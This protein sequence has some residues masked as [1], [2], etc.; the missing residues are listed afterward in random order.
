MLEYLA[1]IAHLTAVRGAFGVPRIRMEDDFIKTLLVKPHPQICHPGKAFDH[2]GKC[3][4]RGLRDFIMI[5]ETSDLI[6]AGVLGPDSSP[7]C[8]QRGFRGDKN[9]KGEMISSKR[10]LKPHLQ[11][12]HPGKAFDHQGKC[13]IRGLRDFIMTEETF[14]LIDAGVLDPDSSPPCSQRGFR[15]DKNK[16]G[17]MI[18]SKRFLKPH[19]QICHPGKAFDHQGKCLI[20]GLRDFIM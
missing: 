8:S 10:F 15:G 14:D 1:R 17:E 9:K 12:C 3:L 13:L 2:Q 16:K 18:S 19:L 7:P 4:I 5:E 20:R 11:I 6:D